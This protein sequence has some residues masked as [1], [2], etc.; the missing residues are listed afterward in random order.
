MPTE[1]RDPRRFR[2]KRDALLE[3]LY[4]A[5]KDERRRLADQLTREFRDAVDALEDFDATHEG[6][7]R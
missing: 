3:R 5:A 7:D 1:Q 2:R 6:A 4:D